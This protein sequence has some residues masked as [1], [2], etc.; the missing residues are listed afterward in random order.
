[1][2]LN[3]SLDQASVFIPQI[4]VSHYSPRLFSFTVISVNTGTDCR[5]KVLFPRHVVLR[6]KQKGRTVTQS[7]LQIKL[8]PAD[9]WSSSRKPLL[10]SSKF[11]DR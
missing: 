7:T 3:K 5:Q 9:N 4:T 11:L 8:V 10:S 2:Q 6:H 1:M